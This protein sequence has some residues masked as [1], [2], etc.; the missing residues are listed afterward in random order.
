MALINNS[1]RRKVGSLLQ[2]A[3]LL[4]AQEKNQEALKFI[5]QAHKL[6][7]TDPVIL[8]CRGCIQL[9]CGLYPE[10]SESCKKA[11]RYDPSDYEVY[12]YLGLSQIEGKDYQNGI[13]SLKTYLKHTPDSPYA[14]NGLGVAY[15]KTG[16]YSDAVLAFEKASTLK[17]N[18]G[19]NIPSYLEALSHTIEPSDLIIRIDTFLENDPDNIHILEQRHTCLHNLGRCDEAKACMDRIIHLIKTSKVGGILPIEMLIRHGKYEDAKELLLSLPQEEK[20][21]EEELYYRGI[22]ALETGENK[23]AIVILSSGTKQYPQNAYFNCFLGKAYVLEGNYEKA[24]ESLKRAEKR[25]NLPW[26]FRVLQCQASMTL[27]RYDEAKAIFES[28]DAFSEKSPLLYDIAHILSTNQ[29]HDQALI[30]AQWYSDSHPDDEDGWKLL[31]KIYENLDRFQEAE[32]A[33]W[34]GIEI[35]PDNEELLLS[36]ASV[37]EE[38]EEYEDSLEIIEGV[39][40]KNPDNHDALIDKGY[41]LGLMEEYEEAY[42]I[43]ELLSRELPDNSDVYWDLGWI[44]S[45]RGNQKEA[46]EA[47]L[48]AIELNPEEPAI[49]DNLGDCYEMTGESEKAIEAYFRSIELGLEDPEMYMILADLLISKGDYEKSLELYDKI[50]T[51]VPDDAEVWKVR[52]DILYELSRFSEALE[53]VNRGLKLDQKNRDLIRLKGKIQNK[54]KG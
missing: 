24:L 38:Q 9:K 17:G 31:G 12:V 48:R 26:I 19:K 50:I 11:I 16:Q 28:E 14:W 49:W 5:N 42:G 22:I 40:Q 25:I 47:Y 35:D 7:P 34:K 32:E 45:S 30:A 13:E 3:L 15:L 6:A 51:I 53:S 37:L 54:M 4:H 41:V 21:Q 44:E 36:L 43:F 18:S 2:R 20:N 1:Q 29:H 10:A 39:L 52:A 8:S 33:Y 23:N 46:I 27:K